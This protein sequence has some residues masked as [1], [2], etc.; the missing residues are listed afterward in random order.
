MNK[1][2]LIGGII[3][4]ALTGLLGVLYFA[5]PPD[6]FIF[7]VGDRNIPY[8]PAIILGIVGTILVVSAFSVGAA[9]EEEKERQIVQDPE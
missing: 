3:C 1:G 8:I 2:R 6:M 9:P 5:L 7:M 4:L